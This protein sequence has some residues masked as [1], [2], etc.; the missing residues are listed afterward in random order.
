LCHDFFL[1][2]VGNRE[3]RITN[4]E[5][6]IGKKSLPPL[7]SASVY[8]NHRILAIL[9]NLR[10]S[11]K[12]LETQFQV[13]IVSLPFNLYLKTGFLAQN[14]GFL[15]KSTYFRGLFFLDKKGF[16]N[17]FRNLRTG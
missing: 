9:I 12:Q 13:K 11:L 5:W 16:S 6:G 8:I 7:V 17:L 10:Q 1:Y 3:L 15:K 4:G 14:L 2:R